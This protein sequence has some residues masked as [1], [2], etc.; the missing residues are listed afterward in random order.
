MQHQVEFGRELAFGLLPPRLIMADGM[1]A[2][3]ADLGRELTQFGNGI[4]A[5]Q[6]QVGACRA[7]ALT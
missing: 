7:Q 1:D 2:R 4:A 3:R 6:E 5:A